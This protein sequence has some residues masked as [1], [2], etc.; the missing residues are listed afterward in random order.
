[1]TYPSE[2]LARA[3]LGTLIE[4]GVRDVVYCPGSRSAPIAYALDA[5]EHAGLVRAHVRLDE[6]SAAFLAI[7]LSRAGRGDDT[8]EGELNED[9]HPVPVAIVTTSGSAVAEL[10]AALAEAYHSRLPLI[11]LSA[12]RPAELLG[13]GASQTTIQA[14][15]FGPHTRAKLNLPADTVADRSL[16]ARIGRVIARAQGFPS[17]TPGPV[18]INLALRDP[19][20]PEGGSAKARPLRV[21]ASKSARVMPARPRPIAW[22]EAVKAG[23]RTIILA[24]DTSDP[25]GAHWANAA[26]VPIL[27]EPTSPLAFHPQRIPYQQSLLSSEIAD[28]IEQVILTG[29]PTLS[30]PVSVL[31]A[32]E[33]VRLVV[34]DPSN[35]WTDVGA[36]AELIVPAL[37]TPKPGISDARALAW[38]Q[39]WRQLSEAT[40][41]VIGQILQDSDLSVL[42][43]AEAVWRVDW[44]TLLLGASNSVRAADLVGA[45]GRPRRVLSNRGLAG[46][47]GTIATAIGLACGTGQPVTALMGDLTF[48]HDAGALALPADEPT[49]DLLILVADDGGGGIF[50]GL[51]HGAAD[52][53]PTFERWFGT[54]QTASIEGLALA[55]GVNYKEVRTLSQLE[56]L[57]REPVSGI[58][59][60]RIACSRPQEIQ[61]VRDGAH[62]ARIHS[63][64]TEKLQY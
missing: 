53:T 13:V 28:R 33:Q 54:A 25:A 52:N 49:P 42:G 40:G 31:L 37:G 48:F 56:A 16:S 50:A 26:S 23:A 44:R 20:T 29:R 58:C 22:E 41:R 1:M 62:K 47:D 36:N 32:R 46:I 14:G 10:H 43:V 18:H 3:V 4:C 24:G 30:R 38:L 21:P 57:L 17:G 7:G 19:L 59:V 2:E 12:D 8:P 5:A 11:A 9:V 34:V 51:E 61:A 60:C 64:H 63:S 15:I 45:R 27:A 35:E 55:Y 39:Q 6:R